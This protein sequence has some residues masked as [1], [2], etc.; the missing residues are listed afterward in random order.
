MRRVIWLLCCLCGASTGLFGQINESDT[1]LL[2]YRAALTGNAQT[3]NLKALTLIGRLDISVAPSG[4]WAFKT[5]NASRYQAFFGRKADNDFLS[6]NFVYV[7]QQRVLYPFAMAFL[8]GNFRRKIDF[9]WFAGPG[10]TWQALRRPGQLIKVSLSGVYESTRFAGETYNRPS[11]N[12]SRWIE[13]WRATARIFGQH[14]LLQQRL[15]LYY[16]AYL[17]P[18]IEQSDNFRWLADWGLEMPVWKGFSFNTH[19]TYTHENIVIE[20]VKQNDLILTFGIAFRD[21]K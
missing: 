18:S 2:Q 17:Q 6:Q 12:G 16:E 3:G 10:V 11:Y 21:S 9:R 5:Q 1:L 20:S 14:R 13:T 8:S 7:G 19:F 15:R 4:R